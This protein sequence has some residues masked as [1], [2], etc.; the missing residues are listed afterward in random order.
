MPYCPSSSLKLALC[1][2]AG[3]C[4]APTGQLEWFGLELADGGFVSGLVPPA[5]TAAIL[6]V[7]PSQCF[8]CGGELSGWRTWQ[9]Q[10]SQR[11][12]AIVLLRPPTNRESAEL[13]RQRIPVTATLTGRDSIDLPAAF[14]FINGELRDSATG[15]GRSRALMNRWVP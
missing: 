11:S 10:S 13:S 4:A 6:F 7:E 14:L 5:D 8:S 2:F 15:T 3:G 1:L 9:R 12:L